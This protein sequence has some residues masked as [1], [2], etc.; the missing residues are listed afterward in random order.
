MFVLHRNAVLSRIFSVD[1]VDGD[2]AAFGLFGDGE[3]SL[4]EDLPVVTEPED[5][6]GRV[7]VDEA[8]QTQRL[9]GEGQSETESPRMKLLQMLL[10]FD[11]PCPP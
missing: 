1:L 2:G 4:I 11:I 8:R 3:P 6:W 5:V 10:I 7:A 9:K